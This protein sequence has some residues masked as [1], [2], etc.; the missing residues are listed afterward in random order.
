M[1][2]FCDLTPRAFWEILERVGGGGGIFTVHCSV[3]VISV[4]KCVLRVA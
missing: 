2:Y 3:V 4:M 1:P